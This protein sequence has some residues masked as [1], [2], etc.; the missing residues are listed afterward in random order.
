MSGGRR[1]KSPFKPLHK[2]S[3]Q[4]NQHSAQDAD[5]PAN[6]APSSA[7]HRPRRQAKGET[8]PFRPRRVGLIPSPGAVPWERQLEPHRP[9]GTW[10]STTRRR[11]SH[12]MTPL[13]LRDNHVR[14]ALRARFQGWFAIAN[15]DTPGPALWSRGWRNR[16]LIARK[17]DTRNQGI[18]VSKPCIVA[19]EWLN[20]FLTRSS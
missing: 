12:T 14:D 8:A 20:F 4:R 16:Q 9:R 15:C 7:L 11:Q 6:P 13:T 5:G 17:Q 19:Q 18:C 2:P 1:C 3:N 10:L